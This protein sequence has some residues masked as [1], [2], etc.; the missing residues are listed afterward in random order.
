MCVCTCMR[1]NMVHHPGKRKEVQKES[2]KP[3]CGKREQQL[4]FVFTF[5]C[6]YICNNAYVYTPSRKKKKKRLEKKEAKRLK[7]GT[8]AC[9]YIHIY[10]HVYL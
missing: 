4:V 8:A 10:L 6:T 1:I 5:M 3:C 9:I 7:E 2:R